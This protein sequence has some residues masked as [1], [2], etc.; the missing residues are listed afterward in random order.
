MSIAIDILLQPY[1]CFLQPFK[2]TYTMSIVVDILLQPYICM[3][4]TATL[5]S[6]QYVNIIMSI[7]IQTSIHY[8]HYCQQYIIIAM[9]IASI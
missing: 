1:I 7:P 9:S 2:Q 4:S 3:F 5:T 8:C 6:I